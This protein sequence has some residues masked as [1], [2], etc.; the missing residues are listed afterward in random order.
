M[1]QGIC[2]LVLTPD[3]SASAASATYYAVQCNIGHDVNG[4][5][6]IDK[7]DEVIENAGK[8]TGALVGV[9]ETDIDDDGNVDYTNSI[10]ETPADP[11]VDKYTNM[12]EVQ[13]TIEPDSCPA[14][15]I[16]PTES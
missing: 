16:S 14:S 15:S 11:G 10:V 3:I 9:S 2:E 5:G 12:K 4:D 1:G 8:G 6:A 13:L 7:Q